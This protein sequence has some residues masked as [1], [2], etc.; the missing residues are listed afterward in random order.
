MNFIV[1]LFC[2]YIVFLGY[3]QFKVDGDDELHLE[4]QAS[5]R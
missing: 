4:I 5:E 2:V 3:V 1:I